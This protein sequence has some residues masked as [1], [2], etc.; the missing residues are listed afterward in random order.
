MSITNKTAII[1]ANNSIIAENNQK[2]F[3][4]GRNSIVAGGRTQETTA[5]GVGFLEICDISDLNLPVVISTDPGAVVFAYVDNLYTG[6]LEPGT[7]Q[8]SNGSYGNGG[9]TRV[10]SMQYID[11]EP[12]EYTLYTSNDRMRF[13]VYMYD[14]NGKYLND[15]SSPYTTWSSSNKTNFTA[16]QACRIKFAI[17]F[18]GASNIAIDVDDVDYIYLQK[19][20]KAE[21]LVL[22]ADNDGIVEGIDFNPRRLLLVS[23]DRNLTATYTRSTELGYNNRY[24]EGWLAQYDRFW[25]EFQQNGTRVDYRNAFA[26]FGWTKEN[27]IP[28][29]DIVPEHGYMMFYTS[30]MNIDLAEHLADIGV[31]LDTSTATTLQ[32]GFSNTLFTRIGTVSCVNCTTAASTESMFRGSTALVTIDCVISGENT[33]FNKNA[34]NGC[35]ALVNITFS[36]VITSNDLNLS[37]SSKLAR[38]S[39]ISCFNCL[40]DKTTDTSGTEW[41]VT[42]GATNMAKLTESDKAIATQKGWVID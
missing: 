42:I 32:Y 23:S 14:A 29:H 38:D 8:P 37:Q 1:S 40:S 30:N 35:T 22:T 16:N 24:S 15:D 39:I 25:D 20:D 3:E 18:L 10:R 36:G 19:K 34:F 13:V 12:G 28:K 4:A 9:G 2:V 7:F 6:G 21:P 5:S 33:V 41:K 27:F 17:C 31:I 26:G 11:V